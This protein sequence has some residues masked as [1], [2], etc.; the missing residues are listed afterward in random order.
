MVRSLYIH[1]PFCARKCRYCDFYSVPQSEAAAE[2]YVVALCRELALRRSAAGPLQSIYIGGG[3]PT[4]IPDAGIAAIMDSVFHHYKTATGA[5][6]T[7]EANPGTLAG[8][9]LDHLRQ[10]GVN[11]LSIGIQSLR[12]SDLR[13]LGRAHTVRDAREA[14]QAARDRGFP[15]ISIDL[16]YAIP[17]QTPEY[18]ED[19]LEEALALR[20]DHVSAY[21]LTLEEGTPLHEAVYRGEVTM[22]DEESTAAMYLKTA[23]IC[24]LRGYGQYEVSNYARPG[25]ECRHNL[26]YWDRG[27]YLGV[28]AG[29]HSFA[30]GE[31][32]ANVRDVAQ[33][34][35]SLG[36][37]ILPV[38]ESQSIDEK[39]ALVETVFLGLRKTEGIDTRLLPE[40]VRAAMK[41]TV[42]EI[43]SHGLA[44]LH[45]NRLR[46]TRR[47]LLLSNEIMARLL[48]VL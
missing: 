3:T 34:V 32:S 37:D 28:G 18:W 14:V 10:M 11:R 26:N 2:A 38:V 24:A 40:R 25:H 30:C 48:S 21:E 41:K 13:V 12:D 9:K 33:Y 22:P 23:E 36:Q 4:V 29:A 35:E 27:E 19:A 47:G 20:P 6:V 15:S 31:R 7:V 46:L 5:E 17:G 42:E 43:V 45:R 1:I 16:I 8:A 39:E 44:E